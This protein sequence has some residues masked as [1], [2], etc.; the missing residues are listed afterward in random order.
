MD[1]HIIN[2]RLADIY[3]HD[4]LDQPIYRIV[5]SAS[6]TE[7]RFSTFRDFLQGTNIF[8][9]EVTEVRE[10]KKY[11]DFAPQWIL[12]KLFFNQHNNEI[13]DNTTL[14]PRTCTYEPLWAF[15]LDDKNKPKQ[16]VWRAIEIILMCV[17]NPK[18]LT[19]SQMNDKEFEQAKKDE[20]LMMEIMNTRIKNDAFHSAV[21]DGDAVLFGR[22][23]SE[24]PKEEKKIEIING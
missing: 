16:P 2:R 10:V 18:K 21:Q 20:E 1:I 4:F 12:E 3:G 8:L 5:W 24:M 13:L 9:R 23:K 11:P 7:K 6:E 17:N 19:P 15:G 14:A 22:S